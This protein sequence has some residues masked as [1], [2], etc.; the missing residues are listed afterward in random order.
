MLLAM[1]EFNLQMM[2]LNC[3]LALLALYLAE[4]C[5]FDNSPPHEA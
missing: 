2:K 3:R 5:S 1:E 4:Q